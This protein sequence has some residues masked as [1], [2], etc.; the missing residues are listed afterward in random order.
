MDI[1]KFLREGADGIVV[2]DAIP[3]THFKFSLND[4][5]PIFLL[6]GVNVGTVRVGDGLSLPIA[7]SR[8]CISLAADVVGVRE[9]TGAAGTGGWCW[10]RVVIRSIYCFCMVMNFFCCCCS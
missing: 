6:L 8:A 5:A 2:K 1:Q 10:R 4:R 9:G 7:F 3:G